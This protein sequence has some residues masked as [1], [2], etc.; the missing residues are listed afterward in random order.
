[1]AHENVPKKVFKLP[2]RLTVFVNVY[3]LQ[4]DNIYLCLSQDRLLRLQKRTRS[5]PGDWL[6]Q[7]CT[8]ITSKVYWTRETEKLLRSER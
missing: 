1:M 8:G 3:Q 4:L 2:Q 6:M 7:R 5:K